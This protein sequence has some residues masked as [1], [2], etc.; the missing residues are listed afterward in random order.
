M[1]CGYSPA[2]LAVADN[3]VDVNPGANA[4]IRAINRDPNQS[5]GRLLKSAELLAAY[6]YSCKGQNVRGWPRCSIKSDRGV[7]KEITK[8]V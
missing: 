8:K 4:Y 3:G 1:R 7:L 6:T 2:S 5:H